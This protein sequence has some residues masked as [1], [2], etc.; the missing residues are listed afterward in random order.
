MGKYYPVVVP[1]S[2][3]RRESKV[4]YYYLQV[5]NAIKIL[6]SIGLN[7]Y[8]YLTPC[9]IVPLAGVLIIGF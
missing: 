6:I 1:E 7:R 5:G 3:S 9:L 8:I 4:P 2:R